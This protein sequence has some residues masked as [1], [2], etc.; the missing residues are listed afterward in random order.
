VLSEL[1]PHPSYG[2]SSKEPF[3]KGKT[4]SKFAFTKNSLSPPSRPRIQ[5]RDY[6]KSPAPLKGFVEVEHTAMLEPGQQA[7]LASC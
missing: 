1:E 3:A 6:D 4:C 7:R 5:L 2:P